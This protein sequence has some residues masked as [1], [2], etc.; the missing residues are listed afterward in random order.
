[1]LI[2]GDVGY[3]ALGTSDNFYCTTG[4]PNGTPS[5][6]P[7]NVC[8]GAYPGGVP[9]KSYW[10]W[11]A[12][13]SFTYKA[14][15]LDLRYYDTNLTKAE[16]NVL[17]SDHT[18]TFDG[19]SITNL[20]PGGLA[21]NWCSAAFVAKPMLVSQPARR[22]GYDS[23][24][25]LEFHD[26]GFSVIVRLPAVFLVARIKSDTRASGSALTIESTA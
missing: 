16:C 19:G 9:Y 15:T 8:A 12:G 17:T 10:T 11:D 6:T 5:L 3:W 2:S 21:S 14:F 20:S 24:Y 4:F 23:A 7:G 1:M 26:D 22:S 13:V 18:S 25:V